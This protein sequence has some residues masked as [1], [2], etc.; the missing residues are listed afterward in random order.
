MELNEEISKKIKEAN[1]L[2]WYKS[3]NA[4]KNK[5][6]K[7]QQWYKNKWEIVVFLTNEQRFNIYTSDLNEDSSSIISYDENDNSNSDILNKKNM[8]IFEKWIFLIFWKDISI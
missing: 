2:I 4:Y 6:L 7:E 8:T 1:N 5:I 3:S